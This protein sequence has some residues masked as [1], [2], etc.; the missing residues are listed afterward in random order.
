MQSLKVS[1][2]PWNRLDRQ[3]E[4]PALIAWAAP[5]L[6][7]LR[8]DA[9]T[10]LNMAMLSERYENAQDGEGYFILIS[11][12]EAHGPIGVMSVAVMQSR[13]GTEF[14]LM[15][16]TT[17]VD[18]AY[19]MGGAVYRKLLKEFVN[20]GQKLNIDELQCGMSNPKY[21]KRFASVLHRL[22]FVMGLVVFK[23]RLKE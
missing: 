12:D 19:R 20:L 5:E 22:G 23:R 21:M 4:L 2:I 11:K 18:P 1:V 3:T 15:E 9:A 6:L 16:E 17:F 8:G 14:W 7:A 10:P 13:V